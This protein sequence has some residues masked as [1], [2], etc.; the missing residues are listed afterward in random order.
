MPLKFD[1]AHQLATDA[2][3]IER[4]Q[5]CLVTI[6]VETIRNT[7][8]DDAAQADVRRFAREVLSSSESVARRMTWGIVTHPKIGDGGKDDATVED[9]ALHAVIGDL[10]TIYAAGA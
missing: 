7:A 3:L 8:P 5:F 2:T 6:A 1:Q 9:D 10:W 4:T